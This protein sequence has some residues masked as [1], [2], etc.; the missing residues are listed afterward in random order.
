M[1][2]DFWWILDL[3]VNHLVVACF[4][5]SKFFPSTP[6]NLFV[7]RRWPPRRDLCLVLRTVCLAQFLPLNVQR[8]LLPRNDGAQGVLQ[9]CYAQSKFYREKR[10]SPPFIASITHGCHFRRELQ[11]CQHGP[12]FT[13]PAAHTHADDVHHGGHVDGVSS[14]T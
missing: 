12:Q 14:V 5:R 10:R 7:A 11:G 13:T 3:T 6:E 8:D 1:P 2:G 4:H 9:S